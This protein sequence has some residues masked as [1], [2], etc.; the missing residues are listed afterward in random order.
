LVC[1]QIT[2]MRDSERE[3]QNRR[4]FDQRE[5]N[6]NAQRNYGNPPSQRARSL[7][8][9]NRT[10]M[11]EDE[12]GRKSLPGVDWAIT[13]DDNIRGRGRGSWRGRT[14]GNR[15]QLRGQNRPSSSN[16]NQNNP[17]KS[18]M[19]LEC[20]QL[21]ADCERLKRENEKMEKRFKP[22]TT[23]HTKSYHQKP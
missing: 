17:T 4:R 7:E 10:S 2:E 18:P 11:Y 19:E 20:E 3:R 8:N 15:G 12:T 5:A 1:S 6:Q 13:F 9:V 21:R 23:E 16:V 14:R 22:W